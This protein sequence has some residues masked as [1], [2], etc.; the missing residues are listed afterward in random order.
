MP[1]LHYSSHDMLALIGDMNARR[2]ARTY[3]KTMQ[4]RGEVK[5]PEAEMELLKI[6]RMLHRRYS[7]GDYRHS[8][9]ELGQIIELMNILIQRHAHNIGAD[10]R[11][12]DIDLDAMV[13]PEKPPKG[14]YED[15][16]RAVLDSM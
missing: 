9:Y 14:A 13:A 12:I 1:K 6:A 15:V 2:I 3:G 16:T 4:L 11:S 5:V 8:E 10:P 7:R